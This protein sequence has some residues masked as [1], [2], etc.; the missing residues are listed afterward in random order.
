MAPSFHQEANNYSYG[1][2][3]MRSSSISFGRSGPNWRIWGFP[4]VDNDRHRN[5]DLERCYPVVDSR[6]KHGKIRFVD[7]A[8]RFGSA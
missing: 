2:Y 3:T 1:N 5:L 6:R 4:S 8:Y 7:T